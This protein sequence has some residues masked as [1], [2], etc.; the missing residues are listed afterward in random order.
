M[1]SASE[2]VYLSP[3]IALE[4]RQSLLSPIV[5]WVVLILVLLAL[6]LTIAAAVVAWCAIHG[7]GFVISWHIN[8]DGTVTIGCSK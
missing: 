1:L 5:W 2:S 4:E 8:W 6:A 3:R 7:N